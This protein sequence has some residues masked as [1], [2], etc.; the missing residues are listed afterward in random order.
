MEISKD[1]CVINDIGL[2]DLF[3]KTQEN[4]VVETRK[5]VSW[6]AK[7]KLGVSLSEIGRITNRNHATILYHIRFIDERL[8]QLNHYPNI[9]RVIDCITLNL[10]Q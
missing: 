7:K 3:G 6:I 8:D 4:E 2:D 1:A 10:V 9:K 5:A